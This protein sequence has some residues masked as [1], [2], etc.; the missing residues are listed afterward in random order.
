VPEI[1]SDCGFELEYKQKMCTD[2]FGCV[3]GIFLVCAA[4][5]FLLWNEVNTNLSLNFHNDRYQKLIPVMV[6]VCFQGRAVGRARL[7]D[8]ALSKCRPLANTELVFDSNNGQLVHLTGT[9]TTSE[10]T[11]LYWHIYT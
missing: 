7:L 9:L 1:Y 3:C 5:V 11:G 2:T 8:E 10:V 6:A 4:V